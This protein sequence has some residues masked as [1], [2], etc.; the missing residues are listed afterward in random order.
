MSSSEMLRV[1]GTGDNPLPPSAIVQAAANDL[2]SRRLNVEDLGAR[3]YAFHR[4]HV[5]RSTTPRE[6]IE[7]A[8]AD[9]DRGVGSEKFNTRMLYESVDL[10]Q[11]ALEQL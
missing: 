5:R 9:P 4:D 8:L 1:H 2:L 3:R 6:L 11:Q 7:R 10:L